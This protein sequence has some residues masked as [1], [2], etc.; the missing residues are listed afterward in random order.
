M[1]LETGF[2]FS[3]RLFESERE[4]MEGELM[5]SLGD[6]LLCLLRAGR[7]ESDWMRKWMVWLSLLKG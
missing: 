1:I 3:R 2:L 4:F 7:C 6:G 5:E